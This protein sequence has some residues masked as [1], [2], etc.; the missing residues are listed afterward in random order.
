MSRYRRTE[1]FKS[2]I[3]GYLTHSYCRRD[4]I[5]DI[6]KLTTSLKAFKGI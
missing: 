4:E 2:K 1:H 5:T 3:C 6:G